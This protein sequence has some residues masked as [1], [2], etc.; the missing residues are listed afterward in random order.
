[1]N[2]AD[3]VRSFSTL[4]Y[5]DQKI[6]FT[7]SETLQVSLAIGREILEV[8][9]RLHQGEIPASHH[10]LDPVLPGAALM[11]GPESGFQSQCQPSGRSATGDEHPIPVLESCMSLI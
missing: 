2:G 6:S 11:D 1:M 4:S 7:E 9:D 5:R 3:H 8:F 10:A